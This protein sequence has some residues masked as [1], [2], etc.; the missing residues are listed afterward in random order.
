MQDIVF[1]TVANETLGMVRDYANARKMPAPVLT[2]GVSVCLRMRL[3][4]SLD[5]A[6][7][8]P[9]AAFGGI[10]DWQWRMDGDFDQATTCKLIADTNGISVHSVTDTVNG[11]TTTF[12]EFVIPISN[13]NTQELCAWLGNEKKRSGLTGE[14]VGYDS[15]EKAA[16]VLQIENFT[17]RNRVAGLGTPTAVQ[18]ETMTYAQTEH[19]IQAAVSSSAETKQDKLTSANA[20][21]GI[22]ILEGG[23]ISTADIPQSVVTGLDASLAAKQNNITAGYGMELIG[24]STVGQK[25]YFQ[26]ETPTSSAVT[27]QAGHAYRI[28][29]TAGQKTLNAE[30][31]NSNEFGLDG[32]IELFVANTGYVHTGAN[33]VLSQ[34]LEPDAVNNCTVRFHDGL[35]IISV[36]DHVAGYIVVSATGSTS[37]TLPYGLSSASQ[38]YVAFDAS[39]NGQTF[40]LGG[41][42]T[43]GEKHVVGNGYADTVVTGGLSCTSKTTFANLSMVDV[44]MLG[45]TMT[46]GDVYI[47]SGS[48]VGVSGGGLA[49]EKVAGDGGVIAGNAIVNGGSATLAG[50]VLTGGTVTS[51]GLVVIGG[52]NAIL[53]DCVLSG[54][55]TTGTDYAGTLVVSRGAVTMNNCSAY[56]NSGQIP[57]YVRSGN[58]TIRGGSYETAIHAY[59]DVIIGIE[60]TVRI[61][62]IT[63]GT[64]TKKGSVT[65]SSGAILDL[66]GNTNTTPIDPGGGVTF[67]PG[68]ATV[69]PSAGIASA[70]VLGGMTIPQLGNTNVVDLGGTTAHVSGGTL[71]NFTFASGTLAL[72]DAA[73]VSGTT[74][75]VGADG[76]LAIERVRG[77]GTID[78]N[79]TFVSCTSNTVEIS[80]TTFN[81]GS[82]YCLQMSGASV[83]PNLT[84]CTF[85]S[86]TFGTNQGAIWMTGGSAGGANPL[87][88]SGCS[89]VGNGNYFT[90]ATSAA[91]IVSS[92]YCAPAGGAKFV[93]NG[94]TRITFVNTNLGSDNNIYIG[95]GISI[96]FAGDCTFDG[97]IIGGSTRAAY[98][99]IESGAVVTLPK[100]IDPGGDGGIMIPANA[101]IQIIG[102][103]AENDFNGFGGITASSITSE[104]RIAGATISIPDGAT[105][106][107]T[108]HSG[109]VETTTS[110]VGPAA[111]VVDGELSFCG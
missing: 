33:V 28:N 73:L 83:R 57:I 34:P 42:A 25:R 16:F 80:G 60:N 41:V 63:S 69:Y 65:I 48:T 38:A 18:Q 37:G 97:E 23:T 47:P 86:G 98:V 39:L 76:G 53:S 31:M 61:N 85:G 102:D 104:A 89:F 45:G 56:D 19:L 68:G 81:N 54:N 2:L 66:T 7:P 77:A 109:G 30:T 36:E 21:T 87:I 96:G 93:L 9:L 70:Y 12:T 22:S 90:M 43:N 13:M 15:E 103:G 74:V 84:S 110:A 4:S 24:G 27:L 44:S 40:D 100:G 91:A 49:V 52:G 105:C 82:K 29:A 92:C 46:L 6:T 17:V 32:H 75:A 71:G 94:T 62:S 101:A 58:L 64:A 72:D 78:L 59:E 88:V 55:A 107:Y 10:S 50:I 106:T 79:S 35:A 14:L 11:E 95:S 3:F 108:Y 99:T 111:V 20:G 26:I 51:G 5:T 8:Y 1:Y 67:S